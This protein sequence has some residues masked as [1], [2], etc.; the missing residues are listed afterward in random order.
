[1]NINSFS[2]FQIDE[3]KEKRLFEDSLV[4]F[5][6]SSLLSFYYFSENNRNDINENVFK[7]LAGRLWITAQTEYEFLKDLIIYS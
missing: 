6:T 3:E 1:M 2:L 7:K 5:D 4:F